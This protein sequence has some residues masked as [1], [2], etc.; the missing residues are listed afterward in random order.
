[1]AICDYEIQKQTQRMADAVAWEM[2]QDL[3]DAGFPPRMYGSQPQDAWCGPTTVQGDLAE[4]QA[5]NRVRAELMGTA[6]P[7]TPPS[8]AKWLLAY[9]ALTGS[10]LMLGGLF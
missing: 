10:L 4:I 8:A 5:V 2:R 9:L 3:M 1:M 7:A 6:Q